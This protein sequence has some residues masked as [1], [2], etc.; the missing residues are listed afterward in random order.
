MKKTILLLILTITAM[1]VKPVQTNAREGDEHLLG[2]KY[3]FNLSGVMFDP[4]TMGGKFKPAP[5]N[6]SLLY[7]Y[8]SSMWGRMPYFGLQTGLKY[9]QE[10]VQLTLGETEKVENY[11]II[12]LPLISQFRYT[13]GKIRFLFNIGGYGAY[14]LAIDREGGF[15]E[16][17]IRYDYGLTGGG[18]VGFIFR[19]FEL[20]VECNYKYGFGDLYKNNKYGDERWIYSNTQ[21]IMI[22]VGLFVHLDKPKNLRRKVQQ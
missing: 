5:L 3:A 13:L 10:A 14:R 16:Y 22:S 20:Q 17:D 1:T 19:P 9:G 4:P 7:T 15:D 6:V 2:V 11:N 12:E 18:G 21:H 8:Y